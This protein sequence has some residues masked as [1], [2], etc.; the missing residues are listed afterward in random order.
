MTTC[1]TWPS[2]Q[3]LSV[4]AADLRSPTFRTKAELLWQTTEARL[5]PSRLGSSASVGFYVLTL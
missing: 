4:I 2:A 1:L 3:C 5:A